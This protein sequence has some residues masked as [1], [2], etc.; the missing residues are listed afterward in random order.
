MTDPRLIAANDRVAL[1]DHAAHAPDAQIVEGVH[2]QVC[3][4]IA[5]LNRAPD[6]ARDR[7]LR[8]GASV[9]V[10][11]TVAGWS[12]VQNEADGYVGYVPVHALNDYDE[13]THRISARSSHVYETPKVQAREICELP[14]DARLTVIGTE[15]G[16]ALTPEGAVPLQHLRSLTDPYTD[17][18]AVAEHILG[19]PY[20]WGGNSSWGIDCSGL[21]QLACAACDIPCLGDANQQER[22]LGAPLE[23]SAP[24]QRNDVLFWRGHVALVYDDARLIHANGTTMSVAIEPIDQAIDRIARSEYGAVTSRRRISLPRG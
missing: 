12:F 17:P 6:G 8:W 22:T 2:Q 13:P 19:A 24:L 3:V 18:A 21:V 10:L 7:Q 9:L 1:R 14:F 4:P 5:D 23:D 15:N 20:L 11:E 16:F